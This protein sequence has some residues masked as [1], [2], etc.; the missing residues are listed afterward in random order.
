MWCTHSENTAGKNTNKTQYNTKPY[1][2]T[3][4][5]FRMI[6]G[7]EQAFRNCWCTQDKK[8]YL[9]LFKSYCISS[10]I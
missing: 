5:T 8:H 3:N 2:K 4:Q 7:W 9:Y 10:Q 1:N 6:S